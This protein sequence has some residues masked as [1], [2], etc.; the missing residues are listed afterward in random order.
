MV[1]WEVRRREDFEGYYLLLN[2]LYERGLEE[3]ETA[4][5]RD[6]FHAGDTG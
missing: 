2:R 5:A 3:V 6:G 4:E 1:D